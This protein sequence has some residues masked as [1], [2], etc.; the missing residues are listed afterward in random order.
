MPT[1]AGEGKP[2]VSK[3]QYGWHAYIDQFYRENE[4]GLV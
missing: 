4:E 1:I 2:T 3:I